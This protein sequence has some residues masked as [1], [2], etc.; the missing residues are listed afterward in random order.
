MS[1]TSVPYRQVAPVFITHILEIGSM[2]NMADRSEC[3]SFND[4]FGWPGPCP[5][6]PPFCLVSEARTAQHDGFR[7]SEPTTDPELL[8]SPPYSQ[9][10]VPL[11]GKF[12]TLDS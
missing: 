11:A 12:G 4:A 10:K 9:V 8:E 2:Q 5:P 6:P 7:P 1:M 3:Q